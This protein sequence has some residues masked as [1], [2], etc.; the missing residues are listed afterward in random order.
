MDEDLSLLRDKVIES[1]RR[2][3]APALQDCSFDFG[4]KMVGGF[5]DGEI[6][7][8]AN[9]NLGSLYQNELVRVFALMTE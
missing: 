8:A 7:F 9:R 4:N 2:A 3:G 1:L 6:K 5:N